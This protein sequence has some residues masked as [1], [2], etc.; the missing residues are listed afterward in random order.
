TIHLYH[1][2]NGNVMGDYPCPSY[3]INIK[4]PYINGFAP[5][6]VSGH[7]KDVKD[8]NI[9]AFV[10]GLYIPAH[11]AEGTGQ[12]ISLPL[13]R[14]HYWVEPD[15]PHS[16]GTIKSKD[17]NDRYY[18][19][20]KIQAGIFSSQQGGPRLKGQ[21]QLALLPGDVVIHNVHEAGV[22]TDPRLI[23]SPDNFAIENLDRQ[24]RVFYSVTKWLNPATNILKA[25]VVR[26][27]SFSPE[28]RETLEYQI[29]RSTNLSD[30]K[31]RVSPFLTL[32]VGRYLDPYEKDEE[33]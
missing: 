32:P 25:A 6:A 5:P 14:A 17:V 8:G 19:A 15:A 2:A 29:P 23:C 28:D 18:S 10:M 7:L 9:E 12:T 3:L 26:Y 16:Y 11:A 27:V 30:L 21:S 24:T 4:A 1:P 22:L 20:Y 33:A 13:L 31:E